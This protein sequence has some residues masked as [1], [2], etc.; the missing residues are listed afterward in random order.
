MTKLLKYPS[1]TIVSMLDGIDP[2]ALAPASHGN[3]LQCHYCS[4]YEPF[5]MCELL[6]F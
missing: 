4:N 3:R 2:E 5:F 1:V 6:L